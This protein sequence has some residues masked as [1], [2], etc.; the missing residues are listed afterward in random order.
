MKKGL[1][2][3]H[4]KGGSAAEAAHYRALFPEYDVAGFDYNSETPWAA[5]EEFAAYFDVFRSAHDGAGII[6]NSIGAFFSMHAL[7]D[8]EVAQAWFIS[9]IVNMEKLISDMMHWANVTE[10][11]LQ[12]RG[13]IETAFGETLSWEYLCWVRSHPLA[14][15]VPTR[16]LYGSGDHL[17]APG[18]VQA[19]AEQTG[20][21]MTVMEGG[22]HW[23]HTEE[24][25]A[26]LD[27]WI[28][29]GMPN[30]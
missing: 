7:A 15:R 20:A 29:S 5:R 26:F 1:I 21:E 22:E 16:I 27:Q 10:S 17:Q 4:G 8:R 25:M 14:W 3:I 9:P 6:A 11:E 18:T 24:Q 12:A 13:E 30:A 2:Y 23:F 28:R 19:F